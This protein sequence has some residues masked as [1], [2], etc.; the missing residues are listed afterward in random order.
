[1]LHR[2]PVKLAVLAATLMLLLA[3]TKAIQFQC[4][5]SQNNI[6]PVPSGL[7]IFQFNVL[8]TK[9]LLNST[10]LRARVFILDTI[11]KIRHH[12]TSHLISAS[13]SIN[14]MRLLFE[15]QHGSPTEVH[16]QVLIVILWILI[17]IPGNLMLIGLVKFEKF[18]GD[19]LKRRITDQV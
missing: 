5:Q 6:S 17:E 1:M 14:E 9:T 13:T 8:G 12:R 7:I 3:L 16:V 10:T 18:A 4:F 19:P 2:S 15:T 11:F